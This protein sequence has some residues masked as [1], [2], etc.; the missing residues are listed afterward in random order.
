MILFLTA[1]TPDPETARQRALE[2]RLDTIVEEGLR[3]K[4]YAGAVLLVARRGEVIHEKAYGYGRKYSS[5][6]I[7]LKTPEP[8]ATDTL[9][10]VASMTK[11]FATT[12][13]IMLL[14]DRGQ[15]ELDVPL[16]RYIPLFDKGK[17]RDITIRHLLRH[18]AGLH[19]WKPVYY[20]AAD[21]EGAIA[22]IAS[23]PLKYPV[24]SEYHYSDLGFMIL[25]YVIESVSGRPLDRYLSENLYASLGLK[26]TSFCPLA[27]GFTG[28][29]ATSQGNP[30]ERRMVAD[31]TFG[32]TCDEKADAFRG[33]RHYTLRGEVNDGNAFYAHQG[34]AGHAGLF[35][36]AADLKILAEVLIGRG[37]YRGRNVVSPETVKAFL[38]PD[39]FGNGLGWSF[40]PEVIK[41]QDA[42]AGSF[43]H[44]G[45]TGCSVLVVPDREIIVIFLTNRQHEGLTESGGY[46]DLNNLRRKI[47][48][49]VLNF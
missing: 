17:K 16:Y 41:A 32:Y 23:L 14:V 25:G 47:V 24:G 27:G 33:W 15:I 48:Q 8:M 42:P 21:R 49:A 43:G 44:T 11:G 4:A 22:Y 31:D 39:E 18:R 40:R 36:T 13:G 19:P 1:C 12:F 10:D 30:F 20:H 5:G 6:H 35:S 2:T 9:F 34:I 28:I 37:I 45:F 38:T 26:R 7:P 3:E 29:A 46:P